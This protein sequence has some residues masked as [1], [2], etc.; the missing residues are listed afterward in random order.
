MLWRA[1][2]R[3]APFA[4]THYM[5]ACFGHG[6]GASR[7]AAYEAAAIV[8][9]RRYNSAIDLWGTMS[10]LPWQLVVLL[11]HTDFRHQ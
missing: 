1:V 10:T 3:L 9:K 8:R 4:R 7:G 6:V 2:V 5:G 11:A